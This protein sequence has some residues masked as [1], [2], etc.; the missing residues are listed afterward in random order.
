METLV[1]KLYCTEVTIDCR[2]ALDT[3]EI[4]E[5]MNKSLVLG[6]AGFI[7]TNL[8]QLLQRHNEEILVIDKCILGNKLEAAKVE[9]DLLNFDLNDTLRLSSVIHDFGPDTIYHLAANSDISK[10]Q[11][12]PGIDLRETLGTTTS[13]CKA[14]E[15][16][17]LAKLIFASSSAIYGQSSGVITE[18]TLPD[19]I[20]NYGKTKLI[21]ENVLRKH[22]IEHDL[23]HLVIT[24]FPNVTGRWQTHGVVFDLLLKLKN[25]R[26]RLSVL[27]DGTQFKPYC[28]ASE[29]ALALFQIS[30]STKLDL[31]EVNLSPEDRVSVSEIVN[32][33]CL[34]LETTPE[35]EFGN[36][37]SGWVGD[38]PEYK[39]DT[40]TSNDYLGKDFFSTSGEA[41]REAIKIL[42]Q[43]LEVKKC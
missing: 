18:S 36:S 29:L 39:F 37:R 19:P 10:S 11:N 27:G 24:R 2:N 6:G 31:L 34:Q 13:L 7:G 5:I 23:K 9:V 25:D 32:E 28:L 8:V 17:S 15:S 35:I 41:I 43:E 40:N 4:G 22:L 38:V 20:S 12:D 33:I 42:I 16:F 14:L 3:L 30:E 26:T 1:I 21:S